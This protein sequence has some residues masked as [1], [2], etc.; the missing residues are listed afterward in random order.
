MKKV[1]IFS[2]IIA[3]VATSTIADINYKIPETGGAIA[4]SSFK[5]GTGTEG[6][7]TI[8]GHTPKIAD[9]YVYLDQDLS[10]SGTFKLN[11]GITFR[12]EGAYT[13]STNY[14][15]VV[16]KNNETQGTTT[17]YLKGNSATETMNLSSNNNT[18]LGAEHSGDILFEMAG[19]TVFKGSARF[20]FG[21][22]SDTQGSASTSGNVLVKLTG[23]N[24]K[25][26]A[27]SLNI[28]HGQNPEG[29]TYILQIEGSSHKISFNTNQWGLGFRVLGN[30]NSTVDKIQGGAIKFIADTNGIST[31]DATLENGKGTSNFTNAVILLDLTNYNFVTSNTEFKLISTS[32]EYTIVNDALKNWKAQVDDGKN[33]FTVLGDN[34]KS[35]ELS[36]KDTGL[37]VSVQAIPEPST[38]AAIFG[39][40]AL[41]FVAYRRRK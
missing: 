8:S 23:Q 13:I 38:Y 29:T 17:V 19:N 5:S 40:L 12:A 37:W 22:V 14:L 28:G 36:L 25:F 3:F 21:Y 20:Q 41:A 27:Q 1:L 24:N 11:E 16:K 35:F 9:S 31:I 6:N 10:V 4:L 15:T 33:L 26:S 18:I 32:T 30:E 34:V 2:T 39:A 7:V